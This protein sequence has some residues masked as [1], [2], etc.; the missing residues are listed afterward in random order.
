MKYVCY[1]ATRSNTI[2]DFTTAFIHKKKLHSSKFIAMPCMSFNCSP[3]LDTK[4]LAPDGIAK[5]FTALITILSD[6]S[7]STKQLATDE[8]TRIFMEL[9]II[10]T[11]LVR[12]LQVSFI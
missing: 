3:S 2:V 1:S 7:L 8:I 9:I 11:D 6:P 4:Q 5:I 12:L 10:T